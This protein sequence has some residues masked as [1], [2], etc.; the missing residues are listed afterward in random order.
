ML[1]SFLFVA[2][3]ASPD[4]GSKPF[5]ERYTVN[6]AKELGNRESV[7]PEFFQSF[8][9]NAL[10]AFLKTLRNVCALSPLFYQKN[11]FLPDAFYVF[12]S[13]FSDYQFYLN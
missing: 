11:E 6:T 1:L 8:R 12:S 2:S 10:L 3:E 9:E 5:L 13:E 7:K 4:Q